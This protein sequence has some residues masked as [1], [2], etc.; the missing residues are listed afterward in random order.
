[1]LQRRKRTTLLIVMAA[2]ALAAG[3]SG[4]TAHASLRPGTRGGDGRQ[5]KNRTFLRSAATGQIYRIA[6]GAPLLMTNCKHLESCRHALTVS[7]ATI[8]R[9]PKLPANGTYLRATDNTIIYVIAGGAPFRI[10]HFGPLKGWKHY[11]NVNQS[12]VDSLRPY[13]ISGTFLRSAETGQYYRVAGGSALPISDCRPLAG[14]AGAVAVDDYAISSFDHLLA[15][16]AS[17][18]VVRSIETGRYYR[19]EQLTLHPAA[20][21]GSSPV[22]VNQTTIAYLSSFPQD[23]LFVRSSGRAY[24]IAGGAPLPI[25]D[26]P[27][28]AVCAA[29]AVT[30][31]RKVIDR[32]PSAP[33]NGVFLR[34]IETG[35]IYE[36]AGGAVFRITHFTPIKGW[37]HYLEVDQATIDG[38]P[39]VPVDRTFL[40]SAETGRY[41]L[42]AGGAP[43]PVSGCRALSGCPHAVT[44]N[45]LAIEQ[46]IAR[47]A[48]PD[49]GFYLRA[50]ETGRIY[51][52][53][54][55]IPVPVSKCLPSAGC[56]DVISVS[57]LALAGAYLRAAGTGRTYRV[58]GSALLPIRDC[59]PLAGC[60][61]TVE[62]PPALTARLLDRY[63]IPTQGTFLRAADSGRVYRLAGG[64]PLPISGCSQLAGCPRS[65]GVDQSTIDRLLRLRA[66]PI[67]GT[68]LR[69][70]ETGFYYKVAGGSPFPVTDLEGVD[71]PA[72]ALDVSQNSIDRLRPIPSDGTLLRVAET[73]V[74]YRVTG[75]L[76]VGI[77]CAPPTG[78]ADAVAVNQRALDR[79]AQLKSDRL[80][81]SRSKG[82][83]LLLLGLFLAPAFYLVFAKPGDSARGRARL[84]VGS[85][86]L[87]SGART[88]TASSPRCFSRPLR[89]C[90]RRLWSPAVPPGRP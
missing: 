41:Y 72:N 26:C 6:G 57:Q 67:N 14:C 25:T 5:Y 58:A 3:S 18:T 39:T 77:S 54:R 87:R 9:L 52:V 74:V 38:L 33:A 34:A 68:L 50:A 86:C 79:L 21:P 82:V 19:V 17:G 48:F 28:F 40:R 2:A 13:P 37:N 56:R 45:E 63:P 8:D 78:C 27:L 84:W 31:S 69:A 88:G 89:F 61:G 59:K 30:V 71:D 22:G 32:L 53:S 12:A 24:R 64:A 46:L 42:L 81:T 83:L 66:Y 10:T 51:R 85:A 35:A 20:G 73:N 49:D 76:P 43:L 65:V 16:P 60:P 1:M 4:A 7:Q 15:I 44:I 23:G 29:K 62:I 47:R 11:V 70:V 55:G 80:S 90:R 36:T 75:G